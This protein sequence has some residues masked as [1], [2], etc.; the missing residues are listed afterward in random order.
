MEALHDLEGAMHRP[1]TKVVTMFGMDSKLV[2]GSKNYPSAN[3]LTMSGQTCPQALLTRVLPHT[4]APETRTRSS[5]EKLLK[6]LLLGS[7]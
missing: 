4:S 1:S 6:L 7:F 5:C 3:R 2:H